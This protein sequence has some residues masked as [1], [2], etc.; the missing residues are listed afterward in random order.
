MS[1]TE[2]KVKRVVRPMDLGDYQVEY[3]GTQ[4]DVWVNPPIK[5]TQEL[6][7]LLFNWQKSLAKRVLLE[8][9]VVFEEKTEE[10][11]PE[12]TTEIAD[13]T[14]ATPEAATA[15][16]MEAAKR[17]YYAWFAQVW[18][19]STEEDVFALVERLE[20]AE[21]GLLIWLRNTT[22]KMISEY[23]QARKKA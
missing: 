3:A 5:I 17:A 7:E 11:L 16:E 6:G 8:N 19:D 2:I 10:N 12:T 18:E 4:I 21:A 13:P 1:I 9:P 20:V 15:E 23:M 14:P 22:L